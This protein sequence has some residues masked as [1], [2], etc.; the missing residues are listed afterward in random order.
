MAEYEPRRMIRCEQDH[1]VVL[2]EGIAMSELQG[3][4]LCG[5]PCVF[6]GRCWVRRVDDRSSLPPAAARP[7]LLTMLGLRSPPGLHRRTPLAIPPTSICSIAVTTAALRYASR[8][9]AGCIA[10]DRPAA[11]LPAHARLRPGGTGS[12]SRG[13]PALPAGYQPEPGGIYRRPVHTAILG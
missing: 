10:G 8:R 4:P 9:P 13:W 7:R 12:G 2:D 1:L 6:A 3:C 5:A 11:A